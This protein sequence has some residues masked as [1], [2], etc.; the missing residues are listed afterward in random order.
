MK[1]KA[2]ELLR[3]L[4]LPKMID[5]NQYIWN[6]SRY[7]L[8]KGRWGIAIELEAGYQIIPNIDDKSN[9]IE[10]A[11]HIYFYSMLAPNQ[12]Y[13][14]LTPDELSYFYN[15]LKMTNKYL[16]KF[17]PKDLYLII[18]LRNI[19]FSDCYIQIEGFTAAAI[20]WASETF[21]FSMPTIEAYFDRQKS[22]YGM[23]IFDF[24]AV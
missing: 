16:Y 10:L 6:K 3:F 17:L 19:Q 12:N 20:Q 1:K 5:T 22:R 14:Q 4:Q 9:Y 11:N 2:G 8:L 15:G 23:Y 24:S 18:A 21:H 7:T 13:C